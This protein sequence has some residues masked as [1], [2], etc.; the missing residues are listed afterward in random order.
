LETAILMKK[1]DKQLEV[2]AALIVCN[3]VPKVNTLVQ[4]A[5]L[6][7]AR[8]MKG[9]LHISSQNRQFLFDDLL[10]FGKVNAAR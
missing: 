8:S 6:T 5:K 4:K 7:Y 1:S 2:V 10:E 9:P 3:Q